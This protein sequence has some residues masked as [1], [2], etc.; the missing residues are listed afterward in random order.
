MH[1]AIA[2]GGKHLSHDPPLAINSRMTFPKCLV[3]FAP[4]CA[5]LAVAAAAFAG[6]RKGVVGNLLPATPVVISGKLL[7]NEGA[8]AAN[9]QI[10]FENSV[11]GDSYLTWTGNDG[12]FSIAL[13]PASYNLREE[14]GPIVVGDIQ[15]WNNAVSLGTVSEPGFWEHLL[16]GQQTAP[17]LIH[18]PAPITSNV[19]P[20]GPIQPANRV[21]P[22]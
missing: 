20:G 10:H 7:T 9:R 2:A 21:A 14:H 18:S 11:S 4:W 16:Q 22:Q 17:A 15:A 5:I 19:R 8:P 12:S 1:P 3:L 6:P 13:P